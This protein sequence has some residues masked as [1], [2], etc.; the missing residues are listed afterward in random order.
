LKK[1][2]TKW[3]RGEHD[4]HRRAKVRLDRGLWIDHDLSAVVRKTCRVGVRRNHPGNGIGLHRWQ[5]LP[6]RQIE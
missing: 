1:S 6:E 5:H 3:V 2:R 4:S